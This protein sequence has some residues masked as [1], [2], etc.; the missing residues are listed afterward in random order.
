MDASDMVDVFHYF[1]EDDHLR[2]ETG[3][4]A[5]AAS[6]FREKLYGDMY[7]TKYN[8]SISGSSSNSASG[9]RK[10]IGKNED[11]DSAIPSS[12][13]NQVKPY[14]PPTQFDPDASDPFGGVLDAPAR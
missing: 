1:F 5:E 6:K 12:V 4:H 8:Y 7:E 3:E 2:Y 13:S 9:R 10:Y 14:I 11:F